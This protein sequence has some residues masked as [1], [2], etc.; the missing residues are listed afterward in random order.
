MIL[1]T[2]DGTF[3]EVLPLLHIPAINLDRWDEANPFRK[4]ASVMK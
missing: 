1:D 2:R 3:G 4:T